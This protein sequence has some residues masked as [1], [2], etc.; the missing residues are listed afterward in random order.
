MGNTGA[1]SAGVQSVDRAVTILEI[2]AREGDVGVTEIAAELGVHKSTA[3][4]LVNTLERRGL[5]E[6]DSDRGKYRLGVALLRL[7]GATQK[8]LDLVQESRVV[9]QRLAVE[10]GETVNVT[11]M[12]DGAALYIDQAAGPSAL[13]IHN[14]VGRRIPLHATSNGKVLLAFHSY[15]RLSDVVRSP[16]ERFT[17]HTVSSLR[18]LESQLATVR[19]TGYAV[20]VN[21]L[22]LGLTAIAGPVYDSRGHVIASVSA[23]GPGFRL[24]GRIDQVAASVVAAG[25]AISRRLGWHSSTAVGSVD[26]R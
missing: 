15:R 6:Q 9:T 21:E 8:Q 20:A 26:R 5:V 11:V 24:E 10:V 16:L 22:E 14:W 18:Q 7:A 17:E 1:D 25:E 12:S 19:E 23:S 3:F 2:M 4:R 13:Q